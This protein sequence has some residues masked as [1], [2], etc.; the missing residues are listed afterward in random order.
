MNLAAD[1]ITSFGAIAPSP[2]MKFA[3]NG[4]FTPVW[5]TIMLNVES[6]TR[7]AFAARVPAE[8]PP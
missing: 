3:A 7:R 1:S 4:M 5:S 2:S 6:V 8:T